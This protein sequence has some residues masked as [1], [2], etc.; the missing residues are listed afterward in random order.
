MNSSSG[1]SEKGSC[2]WFIKR[3]WLER[4]S[5]S[6]SVRSTV[7]T[8]VSE[9]WEFERP[10]IDD[11]QRWTVGKC[12]MSFNPGVVGLFERCTTALERKGHT[13]EQVDFSQWSLTVP[14]APPWARGLI[15]WFYDLLKK[16]KNIV[17]LSKIF[18][19]LFSRKLHSFRSSPQ[20]LE[21][22]VERRVVASIR[23]YHSAIQLS[24][25]CVR[26]AARLRTQRHDGFRSLCAQAVASHCAQ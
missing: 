1:Q 25:A 20:I 18:T 11:Y 4:A 17:H 23:S 21:K 13:K 8:A 9:C 5:V 3:R 19:Y 6:A 22:N 7:W 26:Q 2:N 15:S 14:P 24:R 10:P 12:F 16:I